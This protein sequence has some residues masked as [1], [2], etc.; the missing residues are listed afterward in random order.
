[1]LDRRRDFAIMKAIGASEGL[2][3]GFFA[4]EAAALGVV[5]ALIGFVIGAG[6]A[7]WIGR[8]N[9]HAPVVPRLSVLPPVLA[10]SVAL[11][12]VSALVPMALLRRVQ[13]ATILRG[14]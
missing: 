11:A 5:G 3:S 8:V 9:F 6:V 10:G 2:V 13:P 7:A 12:L 14:E 4:A 1:V